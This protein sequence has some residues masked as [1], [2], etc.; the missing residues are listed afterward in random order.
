MLGYFAVMSLMALS[1]LLVGANLF[2]KSGKLCKHNVGGTEYLLN[3]FIV[4]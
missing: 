3:N 1:L 2:G 4:T